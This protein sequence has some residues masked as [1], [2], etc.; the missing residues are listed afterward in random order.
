MPTKSISN[1]ALQDTA[2]SQTF[3]FNLMQIRKSI[4]CLM[5]VLAF[6]GCKSVDN[7]LKKATDDQDKINLYGIQP[8]SYVND[9]SELLSVKETVE[10]DKL[11]R[12]YEEKT[13]REFI[14]V[15]M[16]D[17]EPYED[18]LEFGKDIG[19][20][21]GVGKK[22]KNNGLIMILDISKQNIGIAT[23]LGT[24]KILTDSICN[25]IINQE[26]VPKFKEGEF[27]KGILIGF[28]ELMNKWK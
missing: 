25:V 10:L 8:I 13:T 12:A 20:R 2:H 24:E 21:L 19:N 7:Q 18:I 22:K 23:G 3:L 11:L 17:I 27:Y 9:Y 28:T 16:K 15:V 1:S 4:L 5:L 26:I 6:T 14:L